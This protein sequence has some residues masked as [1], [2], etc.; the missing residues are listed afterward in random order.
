[1]HA[2]LAQKL[3]ERLALGQGA[4]R[5]VQRQPT[6]L[7][8]PSRRHPPTILGVGQEP[9]GGLLLH[10]DDADHL[11]L[12]LVEFM[13]VALGGRPAD[14]ERVR[15]SSINTESTSSTMAKWCLRCTSCSG[16]VAMLSRK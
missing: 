1:M 4:V 9:L 10:L 8:L 12:E 7:N 11:G 14:D 15:A 5:P 3:D 6:G 13:L 16:R 2:V